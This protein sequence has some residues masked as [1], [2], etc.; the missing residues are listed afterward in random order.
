MFKEEYNDSTI[1]NYTQLLIHSRNT[2]RPNYID[3]IMT[4]VSMT[5]DTHCLTDQEA[6]V[7]QRA[8]CQYRRRRL[9]W[10][11][12]VMTKTKPP[13]LVDQAGCFSTKIPRAE[14]K[15]GVWG[16]KFSRDRAPLGTA[17]K[18]SDAGSNI[19]KTE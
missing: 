4:T 3:Y 14:T 6:A 15:L 13:S 10:R 2:T 8:T 19:K 1:H 5:C 11:S 7:H 17:S 18:T 16:W 9:S 12:G